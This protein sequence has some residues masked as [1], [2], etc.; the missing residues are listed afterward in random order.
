M[1]LQT[2][3]Q[4][5]IK[6]GVTFYDEYQ[7]VDLLFEGGDRA[8]AAGRPAWSPI[9]SPTASSTRFRAKA[10]LLATGGFGRMFRITSNACSLTGDGVA[11][12]YRHGIPLQDMEFFQFHPTGIVG[13][14]ILLSEAARGEGGILLNGEGERF[15]ERY[16]PDA[17]WTWR[18]ATWSA[19]RC[20][21][22]SGPAAASSGK[23]YVYLDVRH[24]GRKVIEE[25]LPDIT[26]FARIYPGVEPLTEPV[27]IQPTAH[28]AMGGIPTDID[29]PGHPRRDGHGRAGPLRRRRVRLRQRPRREPAG[30][31]LARGPARLRAAGGPR[32]WLRDIAGR[33]SAGGAGR[34][35][36]PG[37][38]RDRGAARRAA[39]A[40]PARPPRAS[41][42]ELADVMMDN[43]GV[44]RD[45]T[46]LTAAP[47]PAS[48]TLRERYRRVR[49][50]RPRHRSSTRTCSRP[51]SSATCSTAPRRRSRRARPHGEPRRPLPRGLPGARRRELARRT[52]WPAGRRDGPA[53]DYKPVTITRFQPKPRTLLRPMQVDLRILRYDPERDAKPHW[54]HV[55]GRGRPDRTACST[56]STRSSTSRTAR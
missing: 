20:T 40:R 19:G 4:Q 29:T 15:M 42:A 18:R 16:A 37:P 49:V 25:K 56:C 44:Y 11:L 55:R 10:V 43:V 35:G 6:H 8:T 51:A 39:R 27:P 17:R 53:L 50:D 45:E 33:R 28:Y 12:A 13:I 26:D 54:E 23:D 22:R 14:G 47:R 30:H 9:G 52:P 46:L 48:P 2:L 1:I 38:R 32:R 24:L 36:R 3:Y 21:R 31:E 5:C 34:R 41:G 7:V